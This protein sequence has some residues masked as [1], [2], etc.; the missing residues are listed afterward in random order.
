MALKTIE[1]TVKDVALNSAVL[2]GLE[3][4]GLQSGIQSIFG[5]NSDLAISA[6]QAGV[7]EVARF[8][9]NVLASSAGVGSVDYRPMDV[10]IVDYLA[11][12]G[13]LYGM[14]MLGVSDMIDQRTGT[15]GI[16][17]AIGGALTIEAVD[18]VVGFA[19]KSGVLNRIEGGLQGIF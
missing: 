6:G 5:F 17:G 11:N 9:K 2:F 15:T 4:T 10:M 1:E 12:T 3:Q 16:G 13:A 14:D 19:K 18:A 7:I 8:G